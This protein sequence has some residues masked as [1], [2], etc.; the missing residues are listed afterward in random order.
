M[1]IRSNV[2]VF[3]ALVAS[4]VF[5]Q[6][7]PPQ[8]SATFDADGKLAPYARSADADYHHSRKRRSG[9]DRSLTPRVENKR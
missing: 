4:V 2:A 9:W 7:N 5:A 3:V 6:S 8:D 1:T